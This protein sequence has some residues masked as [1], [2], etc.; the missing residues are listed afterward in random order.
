[1]CVAPRVRCRRIYKLRRFFFRLLACPR[2]KW[3]NWDVEGNSL[4]WSRPPP[5]K[6][7]RPVFLYK[8][9]DEKKADQVSLP[10]FVFSLISSTKVSAQLI[11][12]SRLVFNEIKRREEEIGCLSALWRKRNGS[13]VELLSEIV[14]IDPRAYISI[15]HRI[16][17]GF[18]YWRD[19]ISI[20][21]V[22]IS[23]LP[24]WNRIEATV[25]AAWGKKPI[26]DRKRT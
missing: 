6:F 12:L 10:N 23:I 25:L 13:L 14:S 18:I 4:T 21:R 26:G 20:V 16:E 24:G 8:K 7:H 11:E 1:M 22:F 15:L 5:K 9:K 2:V 17:D 3:P 19:P